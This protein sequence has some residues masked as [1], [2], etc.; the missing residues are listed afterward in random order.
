MKNRWTWMLVVGGIA[1][2]WMVN[3]V[4]AGKGN[5]GGQAASQP[6]LSQDESDDL[7]FMREEE[8]LARDIYLILYVEWGNRVFDSIAQS[9]QKH[10]D[11]VLKLLEKYGLDDPALSAVGQF[12]NPE[13]LDLYNGLL[14]DGLSSERA[15]LKVGALIEEVDM[16]DIVIAMERTSQTDIL[17]VYSNLLAGSENHFKAFVR[18]IERLTGETYEAQYL[19]QDEVDAILGR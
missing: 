16:E 12:A 19:T 2:G 14:E 13:L 7:L 4:T 15:A 10:T 17:R 1:L 6:V 8:K 9:E 5:R 3:P 11:A 18:N